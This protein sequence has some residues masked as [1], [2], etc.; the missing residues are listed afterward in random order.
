VAVV[1]AAFRE[2]D[3][4]KDAPS[5]VG[6]SI[7][8]DASP[9]QLRDQIDRVDR[10]R[11]ATAAAQN[12]LNVPPPPFSSPLGLAQ[13]RAPVSTGG[14]SSMN[15]NNG[16][17]ASQ[18]SFTGSSVLSTD[19][20]AV[21]GSNGGGGLGGTNS[22]SALNSGSFTEP[23][24]DGVDGRVVGAYADYVNYGSQYD[25]Q[26]NLQRLQDSGADGN[27][28]VEGMSRISANSGGENA[29]PHL[30]VSRIDVKNAAMPFLLLLTAASAAVDIATKV[31]PASS[32]P[33][34]S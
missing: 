34:Y 33:P 7:R 28:Y 10:F 1:S 4:S 13:Q 9:A 14:G 16:R 30:A 3:P 15:D 20:K 8:Q 31:N 18:G 23:Y 32:T 29:P 21:A 11:K 2:S 5:T 24:L 19:F 25:S 6:P 27:G 17:Q 26:G 12:F 22:T